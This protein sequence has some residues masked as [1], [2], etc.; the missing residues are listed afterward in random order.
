M[1]PTSS[2]MTQGYMDYKNQQPTLFKNLGK[3]LS[4]QNMLTGDKA[5]LNYVYGKQGNQQPAGILKRNPTV[6]TAKLAAENPSAYNNYLASQ[7]RQ[8]DNITKI[9]KLA[10][11]VMSKKQNLQTKKDALSDLQ[12]I[13]ANNALD[14]KNKMKDKME[15]M[16]SYKPMAHSP[17]TFDNKHN[18]VNP[19]IY[20]QMDDNEMDE[21]NDLLNGYAN[22]HG[23]HHMNS[24]LKRISNSIR[25]HQRINTYPDEDHSLLY[26]QPIPVPNPMPSLPTYPAYAHPIQPAYVDPYMSPL[27]HGYRHNPH[28]VDLRISVE[29]QN[30][31]LD[32]LHK[33]LD[34]INQQPQPFY[35]DR[36]PVRS[37]GSSREYER[38]LREIEKDNEFKLALMRQQQQLEYMTKIKPKEEEKQ[39]IPPQMLQS[40]FMQMM[41]PF[42]QGFFPMDMYSG[43]GFGGGGYGGGYPPQYPPPGYDPYGGGGGY[44]YPP[45]Y[46]QQQKS[47]KKPKAATPAGDDEDEPEED[48]TPKKASKKPGKVDTKKA[49][50]QPPKSSMKKTSKIPAPVE[51]PE[52]DGEDDEEAQKQKQ[53]L[54]RSRLRTTLWTLAVPGLLWKVAHENFAKVKQQTVKKHIT[55]LVECLGKIQTWI[56][57]KC[58]NN[59]TGIVTEKKTCDI[60]QDPR[61][62]KFPANIQDNLRLLQMKVK[63]F[64]DALNQAI[65]PGGIEDDILIQLAGISSEDSIVPSKYLAQFEMNRLE[66]NKFGRITRVKKEQA[67][68][69]IIGTVII[70]ILINDI[71]WTDTILKVVQYDPKKPTKTSELIKQNLMVIAS[72]LYQIAMDYERDKVQMITEKRVEVDPKYQVLPVPPIITFQPA[73]YELPSRQEDDILFGL[74][75]KTD[76]VQFFDP[77]RSIEVTNLRTLFAEVAEKLTNMVWA[78]QDVLPDRSGA[79]R[80]PTMKA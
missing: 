43:G 48:P 53:D 15:M 45:P 19:I 32:S 24:P 75:N 34:T 57:A 51:D 73:G 66:F 23:I 41:N 22:T 37:R 72:V 29:K 10:N 36:S 8:N 64:L 63:G 18:I 55:D 69:I 12:M 5:D 58:N 71:F 38:K 30:L 14:Y 39:M 80:K 3:Q 20:N 77:K 47:K 56:T 2:P 11:E 49:G 67:N 54:A 25:S 26:H 79:P 40:Y 33:R 70:K 78:K 4:N 46:P 28:D 44:G 62:K 68:M 76:L 42:S 9:D 59:I 13:N 52:D 35:K 27:H 1:Q 65:V 31:L 7:Q 6:A 61:T 16:R 21:A 74:Y 17:Q 60:V 50:K